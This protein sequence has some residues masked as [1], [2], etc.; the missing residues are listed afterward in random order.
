MDSTFNE[1]LN[2]VHE[3]CINLQ[4]EERFAQ[5][6][7]EVSFSSFLYGYGVD[8]L[9]ANTYIGMNVKTTNII[10][11]FTL[12]NEQGEEVDKEKRKEILASLNNITTEASL[13]GNNGF[14]SF[15]M[16]LEKVQLESLHLKIKKNSNGYFDIQVEEPT[17]LWTQSGDIDKENIKAQ[18]KESIK[19]Y[20]A[21][22]LNVWYG[23]IE[24]RDDGVDIVV[25]VSDPDKK[26]IG[27]S[28]F[29]VITPLNNAN[30]VKIA[31]DCYIPLLAVEGII[32]SIYINDVN[33]L[34]RNEATKSAKAAIMSRNMSHN[35]GSHVMAY[36]KQ[37]LGS[38]TNI[39]QDNVLAELKIDKGDIT[40]GNKIEDIALPFLVGV[41]N[42]LSYLQER[43]DFIATVATD[44]IPSFAEV[45][46]KD[47]IYDEINLDKRVDR[48]TERT[49]SLKTDNILLGNIA[50]SEGLGREIR[51]TAK[52]KGRLSD[53]V[54]YFR[55]FDGNPVADKYGK[56]LYDRKDAYDSLEE[57]R[58]IN[59]SLPGGVVGRQAFF[60]I[61]ENIIRN[62][63]KHGNWRKNGKLE[64]TFDFYDKKIFDKDSGREFSSLKQEESILLKRIR[65]LELNED[66]RNDLENL[67]KE[68]KEKREKLKKW[69]KDAAP[70][71][72]PDLYPMKDKDRTHHLS[73]METLW[74]FYSQSRDADDLYFLTITD[75]IPIS[76][77]AIVNLR[78]ALIEDYIDDKTLK[79]NEGNKGIKEIRISSAWLRGAKDEDEYY[80]EVPKEDI[81]PQ[82]A[83][84]APLV[85]VRQHDGC[86]QYIICLQKPRTVAIITKE[87]LN[88]N[89][90]QPYAA[91]DWRTYT[92]DDFKKEENKSFHFIL[93]ENREIY[94]EIRPISSS[95]TY[96]LKE[97]K[98]QKGIDLLSQLKGELN[99]KECDEIEHNLYSL[100]V[101]PN[102][103]D[104]ICIEDARATSKVSDYTEKNPEYAEK[105]ETF[106]ENE[107]KGSAE[108]IKI[109]SFSILGTNVNVTNGAGI[110]SYFYRT[111]HDGAN[112][113]SAFMKSLK[114]SDSNYSGCKFVESITGNSST[115]RL[116]RNDRIDYKW[117]YTH[118]H[119]MQQK[120]AIFDERLFA[121]I[122][123]LEE[124]SFTRGAI[125]P[126]DLEKNK[127]VYI[128][129]M[130]GDYKSL[131]ECSNNTSELNEYI[132]DYFSDFDLTKFAIQETQTKDR[133]GI[134][135]YQKGIQLFTLIR[136]VSENT[137][138]IYS[139]YGMKLKPNGEDYEPIYDENLYTCTCSKLAEIHWEN[140]TL[141]V[142][143]TT[144]KKEKG[145]DCGM[146]WSSKDFMLN[147]F[148]FISIHQGLLDKLYDA[149][150]IK[151]N[152]DDKIILTNRLHEEFCSKPCGN[153]KD[154]FVPGLIIHS[155]RSKPAENDMPQKLPFIQ[156]A[157]IE[158]SL[159]DC[160]YTL[161][162]L[163]EDAK[164]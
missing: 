93:C 161:V 69:N 124:V 50:R 87:A 64:L 31:N 158:H 96:N 125:D 86:L 59:V 147:S 84:K 100:L 164:I 103:S 1:E 140:H 141:V 66:V 111:H 143:Y 48:H 144:L 126:D 43:Q 39:I 116:V 3:R 105:K 9:P 61:V 29:V 2:Q 34:L 74:L 23:F 63:A 60:S 123:G 146:T 99:K 36:L 67:E 154:G 42:F 77:S 145:K 26:F 11:F 149:F 25:K 68:L 54:L 81:M 58:K 51:T 73:L 148:D 155:G 8:T 53:I 134:T 163:L 20:S 21:S 71:T 159:M 30:S 94:D 115:D 98:D 153:R 92:I 129:A 128:E 104:I 91:E 110:A 19:S 114:K 162:N 122:Y 47:F 52:D 106:V 46:F 27:N 13:R 136:E 85:Y 44:F 137:K 14:F 70:I 150:G 5:M 76:E 130:R 109:T 55:D 49:S 33:Y 112:E 18:L 38:V 45:N 151:D 40:S 83:K 78:K 35:L 17:N 56:P 75:N 16:F 32:K 160:K 89:V 41:G 138:N 79:M 142:K 80:K 135:Y 127:K 12:I 82:I 102:T 156:Y 88:L 7:Q 37:H 28:F 117:Y 15:P 101:R 132:V 90:K 65:E 108:R 95:R 131:I 107:T 4:V 10:P 113:F 57:M 139:L 121:K 157:A 97:I 62:A 133:M 152:S 118:L 24:S 120:V 119:A 22:F 72:N 6:G